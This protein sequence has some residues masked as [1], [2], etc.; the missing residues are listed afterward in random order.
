MLGWFKSNPEKKLKSEYAR[1]MK[2]AM[3]L[4]RAGY[5]AGFA[6]KSA[7]AAEIYEQIDK[8]SRDKGNV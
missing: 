8:I 7:E 4:Q 1:K 5:M 2:E 3:L 6:E